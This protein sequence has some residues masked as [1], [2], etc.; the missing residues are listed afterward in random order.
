[1]ELIRR[2]WETSLIDCKD[3]CMTDFV[4]WPLLQIANMQSYV[5]L[6]MPCKYHF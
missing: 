4:T 2:V 3:P 1:M 6:K 5:V